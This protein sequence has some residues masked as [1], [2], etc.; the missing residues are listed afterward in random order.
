MVSTPLK[1][2]SKHGL[3]F[4][5]GSG[6]QQL[7]NRCLKPHPS[8]VVSFFL[9]GCFLKI[10]T[11]KL[12]NIWETGNFMKFP[13]MKMVVC[14]QKL[15]DIPFSRLLVFA[16]VFHIIARRGGKNS[17]QKQFAHLGVRDLLWKNAWKKS[18]YKIFTEWWCTI[19]INKKNHLFISCLYKYTNSNQWLHPSLL[20][21]AT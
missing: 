18:K 2:I 13:A 3:I 4:L 6:C 21:A 8:W 17:R 10:H 20:T 12:Y 1:H 16:G 14:Y 7:N 5:K 11:R 15:G 9:G 19:T